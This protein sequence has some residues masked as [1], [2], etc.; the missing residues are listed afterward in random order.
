MLTKPGR[1][2]ERQSTNILNTWEGTSFAEDMAALLLIKFKLN[3]WAHVDAN[4]TFA[5]SVSIRGLDNGLNNISVSS[6]YLNIVPIQYAI[7]VSRI[8][9]KTLFV[10][11][12][13]AIRRGE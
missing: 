1:L 12:D 11:R 9:G 4:A 10:A 8:V 7:V 5:T 6:L 13:D 2:A 3:V